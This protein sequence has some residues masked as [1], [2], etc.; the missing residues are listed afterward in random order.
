ML[1]C[2]GRQIIVVIY[3]ISGGNI[4]ICEW[5]TILVN[6]EHGETGKDSQ[7]HCHPQANHVQVQRPKR[8]KK[9]Y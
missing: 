7:T 2:F 4:T 5:V 3:L 8:R 1:G 9:D 6:R